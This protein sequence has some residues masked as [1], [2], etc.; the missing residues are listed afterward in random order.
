[1]DYGR[2]L[3]HPTQRL[4]LRNLLAFRRR[5]SLMAGE[6][7]FIPGVYRNGVFVPEE[8]AHLPEGT[9]VQIFLS[10]DDLPVESQAEAEAW[11]PV[12]DELW[13][14]LEQDEKE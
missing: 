9:P 1:M 7:R 3:H 14:Q 5:L 13:S 8:T 11:K 10:L 4:D 2:M 6:R 12:S